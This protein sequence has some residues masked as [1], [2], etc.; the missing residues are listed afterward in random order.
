MNE[1]YIPEHASDYTPEA[2]KSAL[3][4]NAAYDVI[5]WV[6]LIFLPALGTAYYGLAVLWNLPKPN[7][8]VGTIT[9]I[10][11]FLGVCV[12]LAS[13]NYRKTGADM[14]GRMVVD[15]SNPEK[16]VY[17]LDLYTPIDKLPDQKKVTFKVEGSQ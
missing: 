6:A 2:R 14:D 4:S 17:R 13:D 12:G 5:K 10:D 1:D 9:I 11:T 8:V 16:D 3:L 15:T 7:E